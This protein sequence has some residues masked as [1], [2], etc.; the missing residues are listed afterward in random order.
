MNASL[1]DGFN[2][3]I[4]TM[5]LQGRDS[6]PPLVRDCLHSW[7]RKNPGW[8]FRCL[9]ATSIERYVPYREHLD[10]DRQSITA[11]SFSDII[12]ILLL[13]EF[14]GVWV[15]ATL[16]C[17][18]ALDDWLP[19]LM[20]E[21]FFAFNAPGPGRPLSSWFIAATSSNR[22]VDSWCKHAI[23]YWKDRSASQ[24]YFWF[25]HLFRDMCATDTAAAAAWKRVPKVSADGPHALQRDGAMYQP[26]ESVADTIDWTTPVF[27]LNHRL[28]QSALQ[29]DS[30]L[31]HLLKEREPEDAPS[32]PPA[33]RPAPCPVNAFASLKVSTENLGDHIQIISGL[34][35]MSRL[36]AEPTQYIDR[37]DEIRSAPQ[38]ASEDG[39]VGILLNG[40]FKTNRAEWPPHP[41]LVALLHGFH[42]RLFQC[43]ELLSEPSLD[44]F[45]RHAPIGCRDVYT[46]SLLRSKGVSAFT[47]NCLTLTLP[48]RLNEPATQTEVLVT[49]RDDRILAYLPARLQP[50]RFICH[51]SGSRDFETNMSLAY[52]LIET[53]RSRAKLIV[54][55]LLHSALPAIAMGIPVVMFF[56]LNEDNAHASDR[57]RFSSLQDLIPIHHLSDIG[58]VDWDPAPVDAGRLK[59]QIIESFYR[60]ATDRWQLPARTAGPIAPSTVLP[61]P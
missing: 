34:K 4:W 15:D 39:S 41:K 57:E 61:P 45:Q 44:F 10:L 26:W 54:T 43:P 36:G 20:S 17:N 1:P 11:A 14:G 60:M 8:E 6:A 51:Y 47:T 31:E 56:P 21:G 48:R 55:T 38:L 46:E 58:S 13:H 12:R 30:L 2:K 18:R 23:E 59:L 19:A 27:K 42:I 37:D 9:D 29:P 35:M 53:Y 5:W 40:W 52:D 33:P 16:F 50:Y 3:T 25:H 32:A 22:L 49:S 28:T 7:E 24:D